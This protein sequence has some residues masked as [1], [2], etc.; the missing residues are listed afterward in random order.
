MAFSQA[1]LNA[2][3]AAQASHP[4]L[5]PGY[6]GGVAQLETGRS[7]N[8]DTA[9][10]GTGPVGLFQVAPS[11][12]QNPGYGLPPH[13]VTR[14]EAIAALQDPNT[15][16]NFA[17]DYLQARSN[18]SGSLNAGT[19]GYSGGGY[20]Q[21]AVLAAESQFPGISGGGQ[22]VAQST[23]P[24][25]APSPGGPNPV[26][27]GTTPGGS[28]SSSGSSWTTPIW[29]LL[30]RAGVWMTGLLLIL[31]GLLALLFH[32]KSVDI[33]LSDLKGAAAA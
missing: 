23:A 7:R 27:Q 32:S 26:A 21:A 14:T 4:T 13:N 1:D 22:G 28:K 11:T 16:A 19:L 3:A 33:N 29:E 17:A 25:A 10:S 20:D 2:I 31:V 30:Q 8:P 6:L 5:P 24:V 15:S 18:A 9:T 12:Y